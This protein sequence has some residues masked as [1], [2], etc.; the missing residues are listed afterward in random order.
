FGSDPSVIGTSLTLN[1]Q[2]F[3]VIGVAAREFHG[4][5]MNVPDVW[6]PV[7][8]QPAVMPE[9]KCL[10]LPNCSW[11]NV[12]GRLKD[13]IS[14]QQLQAEMQVAASQM[15]HDYPGR[16]TVV[17]VMPGSYLNSPEELLTLCRVHIS[18]LL[19]FAAKDYPLRLC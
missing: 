5:E 8:M 10:D 16:K 6:I 12:V 7:M 2:H 11:L 18:T 3:T 17:N 4:A 9:S 15:D 19:K 14:L 13:G 1:R